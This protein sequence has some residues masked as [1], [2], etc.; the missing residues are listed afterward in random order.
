MKPIK[1]ACHGAALV[2][3][4]KI[5]PF[6]G[7]LKSL[8]KES[9]EKLRATVLRHGITSPIHVWKDKA[10]L[11]NID[12]HQRC[13]LF[14]QLEK[15][16]HR[17][18][19]VPIVYI[20]AKNIKEAKE[21]LLSHASQYGKMEDEGL[22]QFA[23]ENELTPEFMAQHFHFADLDMA[24][25]FESYFVDPTADPNNV[26]NLATD[27]QASE[28]GRSSSSHVRMVQLFFNDENHPEFVAKAAEIA[29]LYGKD[30]LTDTVMEAVREV[31]Q[32]R[33]AKH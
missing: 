25:F 17:I 21:I 14:E 27:P 30:N 19:K 9:F 4:Q 18:P 15:E 20:E 2:E 6:Q 12:G 33:I 13:R 26:G 22:Y 29:K 24:K 28:L 5:T 8:S 31:Y 7:E 11:Y 32:T 1:I 16:G 10:K 23:V 3:Y